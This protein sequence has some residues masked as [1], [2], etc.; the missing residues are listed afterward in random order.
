[1]RL[2]LL[3]PAE[4]NV[5]A[6]RAAARFVLEGQ[7]VDRA[8]YLGAD[9]ALEGVVAA[10]A[11]ELV[12]EDASEDGVF[13]RAAK[14]CL[15]AGPAEID[16]YIEGERSRA[17]L[18]LFESLPETDTR[19]IEMLAGALVVMIYDKAL[20]DEEDMLP[21]RILIFGK[22]AQ[23]TVK[24]VGQ[25]WFLSP[26][27]FGEGGLM[28]LEDADDAVILTAYDSALRVSRTE[29]LSVQRGAK[30]KVSGADA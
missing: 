4:G 21:A 19:A 5:D 14:T 27:A 29:R 1:M 11:Q 18:R 26:G 16:R 22:S 7:A 6:L 10:W 9:G 30:M 13:V 20:L 23:P 17:R 28:M 24:Q 12:G 15:S 2:A 8:V 25:R 3:G